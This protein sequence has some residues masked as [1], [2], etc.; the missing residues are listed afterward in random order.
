MTSAAWRSRLVEQRALAAATERASDRVDLVAQ[1]QAQVGR[2]LVVARARGVQALAGVADQRGEAALDV[3]VHVLG[4]ERPAEAPGVD[5]AARCCARPRSIAARSRRGRMPARASMRAWASEPWMSY[6]ASRRSKPTEAVKR[7][8]CS[9]T[10]SVKRRTR[11]GRFLWHKNTVEDPFV[12]MASIRQNAYPDLLP[13]F[14]NLGVIA[15]VLVAVNAAR[16]RRRAVRRARPRAAR[17]STSSNRGAVSSRCCSSSWSV[18]CALSPLLAPAA[19][20]DRLRRRGRCSCC[21][22]AAAYHASL[23]ALSRASRRRALARRARARALR[24]RRRCS[25]ICACSPRRIRRRSPRRA[26]RRCRRASG[27]ISCSTA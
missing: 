5:L 16:A 1:P 23:A 14:R 4:V 3:E 22:L 24:R 19:L 2:D 12:S 8:T 20:L 15:R 10:G 18:L 27:R 21:V 26:C 11:V 9:S 17:S 25:A 13:D 6:L 7:L